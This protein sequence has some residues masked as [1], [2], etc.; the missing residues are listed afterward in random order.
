MISTPLLPWLWLDFGRGL[1][2]SDLWPLL[3][4]LTMPAALLAFVCRYRV[5]FLDDSLIYRRWG[6]T[7]RVRYCDIAYLKVANSTPVGKDAIGAF[8]VTRNGERLPFWPKLFPRPAVTR[9]FKLAPRG[10]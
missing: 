10:P 3:I 8:I 1:P 2:L 4:S 7:I 6:P 5:T 9:F